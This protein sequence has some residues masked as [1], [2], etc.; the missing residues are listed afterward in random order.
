[1][2]AAKSLQQ[3]WPEV[4]LGEVCEFVYGK[5]LPAK[6]RSGSGYPVYGSNGPVG[7]HDKALTNGE[8]I[9]IGRKGSFGEVHF[10]PGPCSPIDTTYYVTK[11]QTEAYLP[12][13]VRRLRCLGLNQLNRAASIPG[14]NRADAYEQRLLFPPIAEQKRIAGILDA[15]DALRVKRRDA[16]AN[17]DTLLQ[18]TFLTLFGDPITNPMGWDSLPMKKL[19][20]EKSINGAYYPKEMYTDNGIRMVHMADAFYGVVAIDRVKRVNA[21]DRD[22]EKYGLYSSDI[23]VSRRSL[24][25]E[26]SAKPCLIPDLSEPLIF[27]SSLI[28]VRPDQ[29]RVLTIYLYHYLQNNRARGKYVFPLVTRSTIS[30]I[31]QSNLMKVKVILPDLDRQQEFATIVESIAKQKAQQRAHLAELDTLFASLQSRA[32][33]GEL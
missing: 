25:Y 13:L 14:L 6:N 21:P 29:T 8:T 7:L 15:A 16:I 27:E 3:S 2:S 5:S 26:G 22:V 11:K 28:R 1:M 4:T 9:I 23:L 32:F 12:W 17:L 31:N 24:N 10:S 19:L 30:G 20:A 18:S 33:N